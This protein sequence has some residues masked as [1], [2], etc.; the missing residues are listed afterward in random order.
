[1]AL[2]F[3]AVFVFRLYIHIFFAV[4]LN[5]YIQFGIPSVYGLLHLI[6]LFVLA[7]FLQPYI[8]FKGIYFHDEGDLPIV[9]RSEFVGHLAAGDFRFNFVV[10]FLDCFVFYLVL[11]FFF[12]RVDWWLGEPLNFCPLP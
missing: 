2:Y 3:C 4:F 8:G 9:N 10:N 11:C 6:L 1:M 12:S 7:L 5:S